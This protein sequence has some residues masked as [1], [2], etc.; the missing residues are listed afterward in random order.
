MQYKMYPTRFPL[1]IKALS[2]AVETRIDFAI[3]R[4]QWAAGCLLRENILPSRTRLMLRAGMDSRVMSIPEIKKAI[5]DT[6]LSLQRL[7]TK[8]DAA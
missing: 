8:S 6:W 7:Y 4:L 2:E 3:R 1:T 5:D